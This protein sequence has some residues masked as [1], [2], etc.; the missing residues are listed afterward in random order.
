M[1]LNG[2]DE[3]LP[4][5]PQVREAFKYFTVHLIIE[6][7]AWANFH[8]YKTYYKWILTRW[9]IQMIIKKN[10]ELPFAH[11]HYN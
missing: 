7:L 3:K 6:N 2:S 8:H 1:L 4:D 9:N 10:G 11:Q 5:Y